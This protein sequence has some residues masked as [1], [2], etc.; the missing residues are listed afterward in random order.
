MLFG[1]LVL[2]ISRQVG[3]LPVGMPTCASLPHMGAETLPDSSL[4]FDLLL[5]SQHE[6]WVLCV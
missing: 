2:N 5:Q 4:L 3:T 6:S 1:A